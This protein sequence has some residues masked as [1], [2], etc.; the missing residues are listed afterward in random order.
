MTYD[1][2]QLDTICACSTAQGYGAIAIV[3][4]SGPLAKKI[5]EQIFKKYQGNI[6][7]F[8]AMHGEVL[9]Q[10]QEIIDD[11]MAIFFPEKK[12]FT[13]EQSFEIHCHGNQLI[14]EQILTVICYFGGRLAEPGEF[15][16][17]AM[18]NKK[19]DLAQAESIA[20]LI[21]AKSDAAKRVALAGLRGGL[22]DK[23]KNVREIII[24]V[25]AEIEARMDFP[26]EDLGW[27]DRNHLIEKLSLAIASLDALL[28][29]ADHALK[30]R[31]GARVVI[32]GLPNAG[33]STLLNR[34]CGQ[35]RAIVHA[36][37][38]TTRDVIEATMVLAGIPL[39]L[40]DVAGIR[41]VNDSDFIEKLGIERAI[42]EI[43]KAQL[44]IWLADCTIRDPFGDSLILEVL[45][46][47]DVS[48]IYVLNKIELLENK[49][50]NHQAHWI[51]AKLGYGIDILLKEIQ[52]LLIGKPLLGQDMFITRARQKEELLNSRS[53][54]LEAKEAMG[55]GLVEEVI[56]SEL[57]NSGLALDR[58]FGTKISEDVLDKIFS[59]FCIGK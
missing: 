39:T 31:E 37:A 1:I 35:E 56:T 10:N 6:T 49:E 28:V 11:V 25:L 40:V 58:L 42:K 26:D 51:S 41:K 22:R 38:G 32:C 48:V 45:K 52:H 15:C 3:R 29:N 17:R 12:S 9:S 47:T 20:D 57:R 18:L 34:L 24:A 50:K 27:Y 54:L 23:C 13:G 59:D 8:S 4:V 53:S 16:L 36:T 44:V 7:P 55:C 19:I 33:K 43:N 2:A 21:H 46:E 30:L 5:F 14:I